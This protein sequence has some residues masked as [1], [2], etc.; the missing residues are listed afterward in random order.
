MRYQGLA[1]F[2]HELQPCSASNVAISLTFAWPTTTIYIKKDLQQQ[3]HG[4]HCHVKWEEALLPSVADLVP[5]QDSA[6]IAHLRHIDP[7][8]QPLP[9]GSA[10]THESSLLTCR[11]S[12]SL[13]FLAA[14][15]LR[16][17]LSLPFLPAPMKGSLGSMKRGRPGIMLPPVGAMEGT[18]ASTCEY[19]H[20]IAS[21]HHFSTRTHTQA[22][23]QQ[24]CCSCV[25]C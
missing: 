3:K 21:I 17:S 22:D 19:L 8:R 1:S 16:A 5:F 9:T 2:G 12:G 15:A 14:S 10:C 4:H 11:S 13:L 7:Q 24:V 20:G 25:H 18:K 23:T 6:R